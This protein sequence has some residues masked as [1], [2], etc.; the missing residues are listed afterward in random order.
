M[1]THEA[2]SALRTEVYDLVQIL[3]QKAD[4]AVRYRTFAGD[5]RAAGDQELS[6]WFEELAA[7]DDRIVARAREL[8]RARVHG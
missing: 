2:E 6:T 1:T 3:Q 8:A 5:A 4:E 7:A